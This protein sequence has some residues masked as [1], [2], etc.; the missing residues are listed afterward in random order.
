[1][2]LENFW[3]PKEEI[4]RRT[5]EEIEDAQSVDE[6]EVERKGT[7]EK[8]PTGLIP[9]GQLFEMRGV[10]LH[11][12]YEW[13][14]K[15]IIRRDREPLEEERFISHFE[16]LSFDPTYAFGDLKRGFILGYCK[17]GLFVPTHFAQKTMRGGYDLMKDLGESLDIPVVMSVTPDLQE[18]LLKLDSWHVVDE[19]LT[20]FFRDKLETKK[21]VYNSHPETETLMAELMNDYLKES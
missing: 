17:H 13:Y 4:N 15:S 1:M 7:H 20:A 21:I 10:D 9:T 2:P 8:I 19:E 3:M 18:T 5:N 16:G 6:D 11:D 12:V 14:V